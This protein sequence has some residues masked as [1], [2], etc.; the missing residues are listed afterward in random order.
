MTQEILGVASAIEESTTNLVKWDK[1]MRQIDWDVFDF[2]E[3]RI[4]QVNQ[5]ADFLIDLLDN[6]KMYKDTGNFNQRGWGAV[7][8]RAVKYD[9]YM[10][11]SR[12][13]AKERARIEKELAKDPADKEL[14]KHREELIKLQQESIKNAYAEKEAV[15]DLVQEGINIHLEALQ[16]LIDKYKE[17]LNNAKD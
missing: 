12:D 13:Y 5:E 10:Q 1:Q 16:E 14:I 7:E 9:T 2:M 15:K 4:D 17:S 3:E 6:Q 11:Q 8:M